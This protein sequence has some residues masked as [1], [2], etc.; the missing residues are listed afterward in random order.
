[1]PRLLCTFYVLLILCAAAIGWPIRT[2]NQSRIRGNIVASDGA[3]ANHRL[4][5]EDG[6]IARI[7]TAN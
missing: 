3:I 2:Q 1:M 6:R 7:L 4:D 5:I